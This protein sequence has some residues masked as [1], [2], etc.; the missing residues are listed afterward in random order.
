MRIKWQIQ[1]LYKS[2]TPKANQQITNVRI[3]LRAWSKYKY[4]MEPYYSKGDR[5]GNRVGIHITE[6]HI[7]ETRSPIFE[8][9]SSSWGAQGIYDYMLKWKRVN[10]NI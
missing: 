3:D 1:A 8:I 2:I 4:E 7:Y 6:I 10:L 9:E 5:I